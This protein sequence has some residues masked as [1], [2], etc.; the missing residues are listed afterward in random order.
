MEIGGL[1]TTITTNTTELGVEVSEFG[2]FTNH[3]PLS[4]DHCFGGGD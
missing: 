2:N 1:N 3:Y 4:T